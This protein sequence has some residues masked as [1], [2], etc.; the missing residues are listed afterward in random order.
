MK[1]LDICG[2]KFNSLTVLRMTGKVGRHSFCLCECECGKQKEL[3]ASAVK[4][5]GTKSCGCLF[6]K[7]WRKRPWRSISLH[8]K[9]FGN[10]VVR[11]IFSSC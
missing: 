2:E 4:G 10:L 6:S 3:R 9:I 1:K 8:G 7:N 5:G 11:V